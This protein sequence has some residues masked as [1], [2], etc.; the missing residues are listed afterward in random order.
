VVTRIMGGGEEHGGGGGKKSEVMFG[1]HDCQTNIVC[2]LS[3]I[4]KL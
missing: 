2:Y 3:Q 1:K 4:N